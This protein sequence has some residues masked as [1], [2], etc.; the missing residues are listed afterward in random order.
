[1]MTMSKAIT[2]TTIRAQYQQFEVFEAYCETYGIAE[3]LGF[4]SARHAWN[5]NPR[6]QVSS[7][8]MDLKVIEVRFGTALLNME[9]GT[10]EGPDGT[11]ASIE[12]LQATRI[13]DEFWPKGL[14]PMDYQKAD[15]FYMARIEAEMEA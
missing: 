12:A 13:G 10:I 11:E 7:D 9:N 4:S 1:M 14:Q 6:Y 3:R 2:K 8:P 5:A 15:E